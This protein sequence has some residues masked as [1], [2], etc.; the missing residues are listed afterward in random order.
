[1]VKD[2]WSEGVLSRI[3]KKIVVLKEE[4]VNL[5]RS[6]AV[7]TGLFKKCMQF[8]P[9]QKKPTIEIFLRDGK[10]DSD[11]RYQVY[12]QKFS[13]SFFEM[14]KLS[15]MILSIPYYSY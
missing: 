1:M 12:F 6:N 15:A 14:A 8:E 5:V 9:F 10:Y 11:E 7:E 13:I 2:Y 4:E 3:V